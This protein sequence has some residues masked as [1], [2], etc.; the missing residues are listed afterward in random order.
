[1]VNVIDANIQNANITG[2][3]NGVDGRFTGRLDGVDGNFVG[4]ILAENIQGRSISGVTFETGTINDKRVWMQEQQI[5]FYEGSIIKM[6]VGFREGNYHEPYLRM[7][8]GKSDGTSI[9]YLEKNE[10]D[11]DYSYSTSQ[12]YSKFTMHHNGNNRLYAT[13]DY[14]YLQAGYAINSNVKMQAPEF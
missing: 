8:K 2:T 3:L 5:R 11:I 1:K 12:G 7:G 14:N 10:D 13:G 6:V 4:T 9:F